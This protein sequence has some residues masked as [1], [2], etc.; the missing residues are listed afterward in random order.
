MLE[1]IE[2]KNPA[3]KDG[4]TPFHSAA[5]N[6]HLEICKLFMENIKDINPFS[7]YGMTPFDI[8]DSENHYKVC[9]IISKRNNSIPYKPIKPKKHKSSYKSF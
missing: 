4:W 2:N 7:E 1:N 9:E 6:G 5:Q 3:S 8:A